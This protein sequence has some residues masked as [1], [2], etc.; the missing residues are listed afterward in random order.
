MT[1]KPILTLIATA[2]DF[3]Q[4]GLMAIMTT[5]PQA[6]AVILAGES[7]VAERLIA[8]RRPALLLLDMAL[9]G[10]GAQ[11]V[12]Q[13]IQSRSPRTRCIALADDVQQQ[14]D[15]QAAGADVVLIKG[16]SPAQIIAVLEALLSPE[17]TGDEQPG[18]AK[19]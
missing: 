2:S 10:E 4:S 17:R 11:V 12:M 9:P 14:Q 18:E 3:L 19:E 8:E 7:T 5:M 15:A 16:F 1:T 6:Y 13:Q